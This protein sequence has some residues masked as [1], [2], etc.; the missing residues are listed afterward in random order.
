MK[1]YSQNLVYR[2][3]TT[4]AVFVFCF[5]CSTSILAATFDGIVARVNAD[6]ITLGALEQ[7]VE[8]L[9][10]QKKF[11]GSVDEKLTKNKRMKT[12]LDQMITEK[13]Q[14]HEAKKLGMVVS[15]E[16]IQKKLDDVYKNN[17]ITYKQ[18]ESMLI[19]EGSS[20]ESY[21][22]IIR[23]Q[24]FASK[25]VQM[26]LSATTQVG[27]KSIRNYYRKNKK[28]FLVSEKI[29]LS[30]IMLVKEKDASNKEIQLLK[31]KAD[32][33][34]QLIKG[35]GKFSD[36]ARK[37]SEDVSAHSGGKIG[38][39]SRGTMLPE[40]EN[41]AFDLREGQLSRLVETVNGFHILKCDSF[42]PAYTKDYE[43]VRPEIKKIL[44]FERREKKY[45][46][47]IEELKEK[48]FI[49]V[50]LGLEDKKINTARGDDGIRIRKNAPSPELASSGQ[51]KK[52][53]KENI[54]YG[55]SSKKKLISRKLKKYKK[56]YTRGEISKKT[57]LIKKRK[58]L[59]K[60]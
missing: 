32:E 18:F 55:I 30:Q 28:D 42:I 21:K 60:L 54:K 27:E 33:I 47:W 26:Q 7:K 40:L 8:M 52:K 56:L 34:F 41:A 57:Y 11:L 43:I 10:R 2:L 48:S 14:I 25:V 16:D 3:I 31:I 37:F 35:G 24:I 44:S 45:L 50:S 53:Q 22:E 39:V 1:T 36:A 17:N 59:E 51:Y 20:L 13:L 5:I 23:D 6:V 15:E 4:I 58:L 46:K 19:N 12:V 9:F 49:Q 29:E 38:V